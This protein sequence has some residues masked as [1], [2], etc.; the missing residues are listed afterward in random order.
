MFDRS[1]Q[2]SVTTTADKH[3]GAVDRNNR[4]GKSREWMTAGFQYADDPLLFYL[5][6]LERVHISQ[7]DGYMTS[8]EKM[9]G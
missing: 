2:G 8:M 9:S 7:W 5:Y 4:D 1:R 3:M 6:I